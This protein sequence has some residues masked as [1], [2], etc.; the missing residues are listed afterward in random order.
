MQLEMK[1]REILDIKNE[2]QKLSSEVEKWQSLYRRALEEMQ[3][4][5]PEV[6][7]SSS[8]LS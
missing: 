6:T 5:K 3:S 8:L 1:K 2:M 7:I 4:K